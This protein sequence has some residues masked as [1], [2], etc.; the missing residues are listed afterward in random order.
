V[1]SVQEIEAKF[2]VKDLKRLE[3]RLRALSARL[4]RPRRRET[5]IRFDTPG[6]DLHREHRVLRLRQDD[7]IRM[8]YKG[9]SQNERGILSRTEIEFALEDFETARRFL[10]A[11]GYVKLFYYEKDRTIYELDGAH[12][13]LDELPIGSFIE[14]EGGDLTSIRAVAGRLG[15]KWETA[16]AAGYHALF[17]RV[18]ASLGRDI[19]ELSFREFQ[20]IEVTGQDLQA[21]TADE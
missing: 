4:I 20:G 13:M 21:E 3:D 16:I 2:Y 1:G 8:T 7:R 18:R 14:I 11:L 19:S 15:L 9:P 6:H 10:E 12:I 17:E 5:N